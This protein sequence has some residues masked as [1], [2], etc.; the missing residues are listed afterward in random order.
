MDAY[1]RDFPEQAWAYLKQPGVS[2]LLAAAPCI[3]HYFLKSEHDFQRRND[4]G[5]VGE[6][7]GQ[8]GWLHK[9]QLGEAAGL[10][11]HLNGVHDD[12]LRRYWGGLL[13]RAKGHSILPLLP[14]PNVAKGK[15][16]DQS[17]ICEWS[18]GASPQEDAARAVAGT[19]TGRYSMHTGRDREPWW[20]VDLGGSYRI[21]EIRIFNRM[22]HLGA[23]KRLRDVSLAVSQDGQVWTVIQETRDNHVWGGVDGSPL[24]FRCSEGIV[25]QH[26]RVTLMATEFLNLDQV[27]AYG[28]A[29]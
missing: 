16:A 8:S 22:D 1:W 18:Y 10:I 28:V 14:W 29:I 15:F 7:V 24:V 3:F 6:F 4:R 5:A 12:R 26:I 21:Y 2:D 11:A 9:W 17:S 13:E 19:P 20:S 25:C 23:A 27:E